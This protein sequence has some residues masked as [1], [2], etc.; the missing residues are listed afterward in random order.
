MQKQKK[1]TSYNTENEN[2]KESILQYRYIFY[3]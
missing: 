1:K 2:A 3:T